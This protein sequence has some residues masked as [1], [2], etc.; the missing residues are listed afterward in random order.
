MELGIV[1]YIARQWMASR[2]H[3]AADGQDFLPSTPFHDF[4]AQNPDHPLHQQL[5]AAVV[6][7]PDAETAGDDNVIKR[8]ER[9][10]QHLPPSTRSN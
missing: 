4:L 5:Y 10:S 1:G 6:N 3:A 7:I 9:I 2:D 8:T